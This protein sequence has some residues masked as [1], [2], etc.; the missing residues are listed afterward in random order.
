MRPDSNLLF[1]FHAVREALRSRRRVI[2]HLWATPA[3]AERLAQE[4][5]AKN[6]VPDLVDAKAIE[7]RLPPESVH[8]GL[9]VEAAPLEDLGIE[10][11]PDAGLVLVLDQVTDPHNVGAIIRTA[12]AF[13]IDAIV[14]TERHSPALT[15]IVAKTASGALE[16]VPVITAVNLARAL[17]HIAERGYVLIGLDSEGPTSL[18]N[19]PLARPLALVLGAE[20]KGLRRLTREK[21]DHLARIDMP[22][23]IKSLNV[24]NACAVALT[25]LSLRLSHT[26]D[27]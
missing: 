2:R 8:Q 5:A 19:M 15:G 4:I 27:R 25:I 20:G 9:L 11:L 14:T 23:P 16:H 21:C 17:E 1:G 12:A 7:A 22:G 24:S 26:L 18:E 13:N 6:I 10:D 3:A